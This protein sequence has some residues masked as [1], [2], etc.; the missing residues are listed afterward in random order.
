MTYY[1]AT[2]RIVQFYA[3]G[4]EPQPEKDSMLLSVAVG[5]IAVSA[6][7]AMLMWK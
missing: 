7:G 4:D 3:Y 6:I 1:D 5:V 2:E